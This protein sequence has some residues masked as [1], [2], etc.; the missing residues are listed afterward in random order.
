MIKT[1]SPLKK[2]AQ[3]VT[4]LSPVSHKTDLRRAAR[5][6]P[7]KHAETDYARQAE[8]RAPTGITC[9]KMGMGQNWFTVFYQDSQEV[10]RASL[11]H[12]TIIGR[13]NSNKVM[14]SCTV[15]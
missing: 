2:N 12:D 5:Q 15:I 10:G 9:G 14:Q 13:F 8:I 7:S 3:F 4:I 6:F 11:I 1:F